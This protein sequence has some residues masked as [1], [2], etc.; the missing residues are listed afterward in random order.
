MYISGRG[1]NPNG[2]ANRDD[3]RRIKMREYQSL[4]WPVIES[5]IRG[6]RLTLLYGPPGTGK[7]T[8]A[9][10]AARSLKLSAYNVTLTDETPAAELRGH[11]LPSRQEWS[12]MDGPTLSAYRNGGM[13]VLNELDHA[14]GDALDFLHNLLDDPS[15]SSM[16]LPSGETVVPHEDFR[17]VGTMNGEY[18]ALQEDRPAIA[19]RFAVAVYVGTPH[20]DAI[21]SLPDDLQAAAANSAGADQDEDR[22]ATL[23]RFKAYAQL[24]ETVGQD[25]AAAAV[26]AHRAE[27]VL[28]AIVLG[29]SR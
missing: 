8:A 25:A 18:R 5:V 26:F 22:P 27:D 14:S 20:P 19:E 6:S 12:W 7:T 16:T 17:V 13:L 2:P 15:A 1:E 10:N 24:R 3:P 9:I 4:E 28:A 21:A 29:G 11:F 23:R